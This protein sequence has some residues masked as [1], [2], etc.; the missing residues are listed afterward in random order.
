M[1]KSSKTITSPTLGVNPKLLEVLKPLSWDVLVEAINEAVPFLPP[2]ADSFVVY[3][4]PVSDS[5]SSYRCVPPYRFRR[6]SALEAHVRPDLP[7]YFPQ[8]SHTDCASPYSTAASSPPNPPAAHVVI[9]PRCAGGKP[10]RQ[11]G[12]QY[13]CSICN[14]VFQRRD[15]AKRHIE[16]AGVRVSCK[17]CGKPASGRRGDGRRR[18]LLKNKTCM[19]VWEAGYKAGR[20]TERS[21]EDAYN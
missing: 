9:N 11:G 16:S 3:P 12:G 10:V 15:I 4:G 21:V 7:S 2:C 20:F 19:K 18:H 6:A 5:G 13:S 1:I 14:H 17:Y 8:P